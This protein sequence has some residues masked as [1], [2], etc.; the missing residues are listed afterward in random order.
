MPIKQFSDL[1]KGLSASDALD[2]DFFDEALNVSYGRDKSLKSRNGYEAFGD[3]VP[4]AAVTLD[5]M[6]ATTGW[7]ASD[8]A[9]TVAAGAAMR[10]TASLSFAI[11]PTAASKATLT[12]TTLSADISSA[13][14]YVGFFAKVP[15]GFNAGL[16]NVK[17]R[18]GSDASNFY[19]WTLP[20]LAEGKQTFV[21]LKFSDATA[22]GTP[23]DASSAYCRLQVSY[24][25]G[26]AAQAG[27]L[28][29]D[30]RAYS[31]NSSNPV[32][33][34]FTHLRDDTLTPYLVAASGTGL[35]SYE[36]SGYWSLVASGLEEYE[37]LWPDARTRWS[38]CVYKNVLY[39]CDGVNPYCS[40]NGVAFAQYG[41]Q[42][43]VRF[44]R[45]M[46]DRVFGAGQ[47]ANPQTVY[48]TSSLPV[49][50][51]TLNANSGVVGGDEQGRITG[52]K[53]IG[54]TVLCGKDRKVYSV[55]YSTFGATPIDARNGILSHRSV[56]LVGNGMLYYN[57]S[58]IDQLNRR[59]GV[60]GAA[61][62]ENSPIGDEIFPLLSGIS[63]RFCDRQ[64]VFGF[65]SPS[66]KNYY[67]GFPSNG[68]VPDTFLVFSGL[69]GGWTKYS[70]PSSYDMAEY[71]DA[72]GES[73]LLLAPA[74][75][76]QLI[77]AE[78]GFTDAGDAFACNVTSKRRDFGTPGIMKSFDFVDFIGYKSVGDPLTVSAEID[79]AI[80]AQG[81]VTDDMLDVTSSV[82]GIST[83]PLAT[84]PI[85]G[86]GNQSAAPELDT[87]PFVI[88]L[89]VY[90][91]GFTFR[92]SAESESGS[93][94]WSL[95]KVRVSVE[96]EQI[97]L[98]ASSSL[99]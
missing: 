29:D 46:A 70:F 55:A 1:S 25:A 88:R 36:P 59:T 20:A 90:A 69:L 33:S 8:D 50:A 62:L 45:Y 56:Q 28:I 54:D 89:P 82:L 41:A 48:Y 10:G 61:A 11:T 78:Y 73:F 6:D 2:T 94:A 15:A 32:T 63:G 83:N 98:I 84:A 34:I 37:T 35:W 3:P 30:L 80:V 91:N 40:W 76:G 38:F 92:W 5:L 4:D 14:G 52:I 72:D 99:A 85:G 51:A 87:Y 74:V 66:L 19:E 31:A 75:G 60:T 81:Q 9:N 21:A 93:I 95:Q 58:G 26:Y 68:N 7:S 17:L 16:T 79:G 23:V 96:S 67:V 43:K 97:D 27:I 39:G 22:T 24:G 12:K 57:D 13:K 77:R 44:L 42:P 18:L 53:D 47:D 49:D 86:A 64:A 71:R 65:Y